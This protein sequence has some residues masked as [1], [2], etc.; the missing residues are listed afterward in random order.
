MANETAESKEKFIE[1][2]TRMLMDGKDGT[3]MVLV[4]TGNGLQT[5]CNS[6]SFSTMFGILASAE[7]YFDH[8]YR[9]SLL[10]GQQD[11]QERTQK[12]LQEMNRKETRN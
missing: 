10:A 11:N 2:V 1:I 7:K 4:D 9:Q 12:Y 8:T 5:I 6:T 3:V